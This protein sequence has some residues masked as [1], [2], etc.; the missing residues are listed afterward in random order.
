MK[1]ITCAAIA[2]V[3]CLAIGTAE[4]QAQQ[5]CQW[6]PFYPGGFYNYGYNFNAPV[7]QREQPPYFALF[8][9][10]YYSDEIVHR[11]VGVSPFAA[12]PGVTPVEMTIRV[13]PQVVRNPFFDKKARPVTSGKLDTDT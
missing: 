2:V 12:P 9:P 7:F 11:P 6:G 4:A 8:P 3:A 10:V 13:E 1:R 5:S